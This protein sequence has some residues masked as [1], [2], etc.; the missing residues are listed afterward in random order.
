M[1]NQRYEKCLQDLQAEI[2]LLDEAGISPADRIRQ[3]V[4]IISRVTAD[5]RE[6]V[7]QDGF[8]DAAQEISFFKQVKP[9]M[10]ALRLFET[11]FY[12]LCTGKPEG[13][14]EMLKAYYEAELLQVFRE[15]KVN[16]FAYAYYKAG[17]CELDHFYFI[18]DAKLHDL[19]ICELIDPSPGFSTAMDYSFA[20]FIAYE[21]LRDHL[22]QQLTNELIRE[23]VSGAALNELPMIRWTGDSINLAELGYGIWLTGQVNN[24]HATITEILAVLESIF[25]IRIGTAFRRW[26]SI[27]RR[28]R[29]SQTKYTDEMKAALVKRLDDENS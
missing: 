10:L 7:L 13:T 20:K 5:V 14:P 12:N 18:R 1:Y 24:G 21:K 29:L 15:F 28:K 16:P 26:Q 11:L 27:S 4:P 25:N 23:K 8:G 17:A 19:P 22:L 9:Q 2:K 6:Q 3:S